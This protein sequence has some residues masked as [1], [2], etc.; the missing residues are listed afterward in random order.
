MNPTPRQLRRRREYRRVERVPN[1][2]NGQ[3]LL[4]A[5]TATMTA[6]MTA[7]ACFASCFQHH[8]Q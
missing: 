2:K 3:R 5:V 8:V 4:V 6:A 1:F 7:A